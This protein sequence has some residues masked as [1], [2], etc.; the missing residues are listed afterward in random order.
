MDDIAVGMRPFPTW[1]G[2]GTEARMDH[3]EGGNEVEVGEIQI[4]IAELF[5]CQHPFIDDGLGRE[6]GDIEFPALSFT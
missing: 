1:E 2:V 4:E 6:A 5:R 3:P